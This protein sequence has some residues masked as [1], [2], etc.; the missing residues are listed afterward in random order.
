MC[1]QFRHPK[2]GAGNK[3]ILCLVSC[4]ADSAFTSSSWTSRFRNARGGHGSTTAPLRAVGAH[5]STH[6]SFFFLLT[7]LSA[8][9]SECARLLSLPPFL[10][11]LVLLLPI[12]PHAAAGRTCVLPLPRLPSVSFLFKKKSENAAK[13]IAHRNK[14]RATGIV[15]HAPRNT[16][17]AVRI[18]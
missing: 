11:P 17:H 14:H 6:S 1:V 16:H 15:R 8:S 5:L 18:A 2:D 9:S 13:S 7:L 12:P 4:R 3:A 10:P